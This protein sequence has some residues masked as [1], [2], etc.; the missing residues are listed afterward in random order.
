VKILLA[1]ILILFPIETVPESLLDQ[2]WDAM[3]LGAPCSTKTD[4]IEM[5][6]CKIEVKNIHWK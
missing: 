2:W 1:L 5:P 3:H 6:D 4:L